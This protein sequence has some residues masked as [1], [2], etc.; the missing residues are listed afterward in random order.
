MAFY[1]RKRDELGLLS[2]IVVLKELGKKNS[3]N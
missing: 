3:K 2:L 1:P